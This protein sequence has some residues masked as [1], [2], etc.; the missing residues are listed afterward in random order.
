M[1]V[2]LGL[3]ILYGAVRLAGGGRCYDEGIYV[4]L[5]VP[6]DYPSNITSLLLIKT[7]KEITTSLFTSPNLQS[8]K[9]LNLAL[10]GIENVHA[11]AFR[12]FEKLTSFVL[13]GNH[14][15]TI[16]PDWFHE[17]VPLE[18]L[19]VAN[20]SIDEIG[21]EMLAGLSSLQTL[22]FSS[23]RISK[24]RGGS[25]SDLAKLFFL[26]LSSNSLSYLPNDLLKPLQNASF[27]LGNNPWNCSCPHKDFAVFL[28]ELRNSS[29]LMDPEKVVCHSPPTLNGTSVWN[30]T[31]DNCSSTNTENQH[32]VAQPII[33]TVLLVILGCLLLCLIAWIIMCA[34]P[35]HW[36]NKVRNTDEHRSRPDCN[37]RKSSA[38]TT[39]N[40]LLVGSVISHSSIK[41]ESASVSECRC[42]KNVCP[43]NQY[44]DAGAN[45]SHKINNKDRDQVSG[46]RLKSP[47]GKGI[48]RCLSSP[49]LFP[50][51]SQLQHLK[52]PE[53]RA[54]HPCSAEMPEDI[55]ILDTPQSQTESSKNI[56]MKDS[57]DQD[58]KSVDTC[59]TNTG[60][61]KYLET[62]QQEQTM[63]LTWKPY[64]NLTL[65]KK[66]QTWSTFL[67][68]PNDSTKSI[69]VISR[70][71]EGSTDG[72]NA[73]MLPQANQ[74]LLKMNHGHYASAPY[75]KEHLLENEVGCIRHNGS[76]SQSQ[77]E[78]GIFSLQCM[79]SPEDEDIFLKNGT[80]DGNLKPSSKLSPLPS[81]Q[82]GHVFTPA[83]KKSI[84]YLSEIETNLEDSRGK[85][86]SSELIKNKKTFPMLYEQ[87]A[88]ERFWKYHTNCC[89]EY[90]PCP[91]AAKVLKQQK[92][93][94]AKS[95]D[96]QPLSTPP[97]DEELL[98]GNERLQVNLL[99]RL[100][101]RKDF[102]N[103]EMPQWK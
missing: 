17:S 51:D 68:L 4:C 12:I 77:P 88:R 50:S 59:Y 69:S 45:S 86:S 90:T 2:L 57:S 9:R 27:K 80:E 47:W 18:A 92:H 35:N 5:S 55:C 62:E 99:V 42:G 23:N 65:T 72:V 100:S 63:T 6:K 81:C 83:Q 33:G 28:Q 73:N 91:T 96:N 78:K 16:S 22:D 36:K 1:R 19:N 43:R 75:Q 3:M 101:Q 10:N 30:I 20:N 89:D 84:S 29:R 74:N 82:L 58:S 7:A 95:A 66:S 93:L 97:S 26:D 85:S 13:H 38:E 48:A 49:S 21:P 60:M 11:G 102:R 14:L 61:V 56:C 39:P 32:G 52:N 76:M 64:L 87:P 98:E 70:D 53:V 34:L 40:S 31:F 37:L 54:E 94:E 79:P 71:T 41:K 24:I 25:F 46:T 67:D 15:K 44:E 103:A 8:V